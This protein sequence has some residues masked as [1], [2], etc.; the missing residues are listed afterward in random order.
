MLERTKAD[1]G[2]ERKNDNIAAFSN[3]IFFLL[4]FFGKAARFAVVEYP[5]TQKAIHICGS[6]TQ[7]QVSSKFW[8]LEF[9]MY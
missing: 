3:T 7:N 1:K 8:L 6:K 2:I 5:G 4:Y 9:L